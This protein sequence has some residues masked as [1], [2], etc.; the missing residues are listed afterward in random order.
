MQSQSSILDI[1]V[2]KDQ[3]DLL[4][5]FLLHALQDHRVVLTGVAP[6]LLQQLRDYA[7]GLEQRLVEVGLFLAI[8]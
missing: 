6:Q 4:Y 2:F 5:Y 1:R 3:V 8:S 7:L